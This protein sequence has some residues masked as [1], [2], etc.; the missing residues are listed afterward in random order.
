MKAL[1]KE[2]E[3]NFLNYLKKFWIIVNNKKKIYVNCYCF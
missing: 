1:I 2:I 3:L